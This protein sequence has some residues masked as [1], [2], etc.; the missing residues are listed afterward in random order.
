MGRRQPSKIDRLPPE[1]REE[2]GRLRTDFGWTLDELLGKLREL[3]HTEISRSSL[4]RHTAKIDAVGERMRKSRAIAEALVAKLGDAPESKIGR[5]NIELLND[6]I[7]RLVSAEEVDGSEAEL[8]AMDTMRL[9]KAL[10][11]LLSSAKA[12]VDRIEKLEKRAS[13][14]AKV[15]AAEEATRVARAKGL[16]KD[17]VEAIRFAVLGSDQ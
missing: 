11:S 17:T 10:Q 5:L 1:V 12:D 4:G 2:I 8:S 6:Q 7:F 3:G 15:E 14:K 13:E 9:S 16:S